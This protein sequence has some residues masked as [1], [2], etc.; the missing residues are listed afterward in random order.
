MI[1]LIEEHIYHIHQCPETGDSIDMKV[2]LKCKYFSRT[3]PN[4]PPVNVGLTMHEKI[5]CSYSYP[6]HIMTKR[7][8]NQAVIYESLN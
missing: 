7:E 8:K 5:Y 4:R 6:G 2:C 1:R 3:Y